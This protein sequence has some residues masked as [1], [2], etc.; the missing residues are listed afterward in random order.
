MT[1]G[2]SALFAL[3]SLDLLA[4]TLFAAR[5]SSSVV[6]S[7]SH[8]ELGDH[9]LEFVRR[10]EHRHFA[11][12]DGNDLASARVAR[13]SGLA[14]LDLK[15]PEAANL[16]VVSAFD[17]LL[18]SVEERVNYNRDVGAGESRLFRNFFD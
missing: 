12:G 18:D 16:D 17:G 14:E 2:T 5:H 8:L 4:F 11:I 3:M 1:I 7:R 10:L 6:T 15:G 13:H 9:V